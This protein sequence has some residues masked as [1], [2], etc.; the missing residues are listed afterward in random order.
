MLVP[1][2]TGEGLSLGLWV[3]ATRM[4]LVGAGVG[5]GVALET[6]RT[7]VC[8]GGPGPWIHKSQILSPLF[9]LGESS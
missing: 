6:A 1:G 7:Q 8:W 5:I 3:Q 4:V 9:S 2:S